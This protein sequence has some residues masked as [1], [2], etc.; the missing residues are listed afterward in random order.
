ML[1]H[2]GNI[3]FLSSFFLEEMRDLLSLVNEIVFFSG[4][5]QLAEETVRV[6]GEIRY[7]LYLFLETCWAKVWI[8]KGKHLALK[9]GKSE[10]T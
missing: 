6:F 4:S 5:L 9:L 8:K 1:N 7:P 3:S 10:W 2:R